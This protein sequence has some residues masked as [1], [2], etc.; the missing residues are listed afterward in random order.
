[1]RQKDRTDDRQENRANQRQSE[2]APTTVRG[3]AP[4]TYGAGSLKAINS[5]LYPAPLTATTMY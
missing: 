3:I 5:P 1:M 2:R 4:T